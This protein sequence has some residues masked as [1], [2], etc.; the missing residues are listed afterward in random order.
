MMPT[1][2]HIEAVTVN[3]NSSV[4]AELML[5]SLRAHH[6]TLS[7]HL[8]VIDN[9]SVD[10]EDLRALRRFAE[11]TGIAFSTSE[12]TVEPDTPNSHGRS[13]RDF[14]L[15]HPICSHYL[16]ID[17]DIYFLS[18][19]TLDRMLQE[20]D[21]DD[22][23]FG[24]M[25]ICTWDGETDHTPRDGMDKR[26]QEARIR[27]TIQWP[28]H[29]ASSR[30]QGMMIRQPRIHPYCALL[31]NT[32]TLQ[33]IAREIGFSLAC[34]IAPSGGRLWDTLGLATA[35]MKTHGYHFLESKE[36]VFHFF[37]VSYDPHCIADKQKK[38]RELLDE[39]RTID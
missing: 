16:F 7:I 33:T 4:F 8:T 26:A 11:Q 37:G 36:M 6:P 2:A 19:Y 10:V 5:R 21:E 20:L 23:A 13:L 18:S 30:R 25:P 39:L 9:H 31:K 32:P 28:G 12:F 17:P 15:G 34:T 1:P 38:C 22:S 24:I 27:Y 35:V 3:H 14:V 29:P